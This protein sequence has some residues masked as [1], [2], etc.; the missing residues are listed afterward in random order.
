MV[1]ELFRQGTR[2]DFAAKSFNE[3]SY[4]FLNRSGDPFI[5]DIRRLMA[6][7]LSHIPSLHIADLQCRLK[8]KD[9][10]EFESAF[11]ELYLHE[12]YQRSG[13]RLTIHPA[14]AGTTRHPDFLIEGDG[15]RFYLEAVRACAPSSSTGENK[16]LEDARRVL[17]T[18]RA[19]RYMLDMA[20]YAIGARPLQVKVLRRDLREWLADLDLEANRHP[21]GTGSGTLH[22]LPWRQED[23]WRLEFTA[24]PLRPEHVGTGLPLIRA[25]LTMGWGHDADRILAALDEKANKYGPLEAPLVIAVLSNTQFRTEDFDVERALFGALNGRPSPQPPEARQVLEPGHW[26]TGKGWRRA[27]APQVIT[28]HDLYPWTITQAQPRLWTTLQAGVTAPTQP[29]WLA[30]MRVSGTMPVPAAADSLASLFDLPPDWP[31]R[32]PH[33]VTRSR[34]VPL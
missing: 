16:R 26:C 7:W 12:A 31:A 34:A 23:G 13:Y 5:E 19:D 20:T 30:V 18:L 8:S 29:G 17:A 4:D 22:R 21:A 15:T 3:P 6:G 9:D 14:V 24:Q 1:D 27:H 11:W 10:A 28:V 25:H 32:E 2:T 33:F